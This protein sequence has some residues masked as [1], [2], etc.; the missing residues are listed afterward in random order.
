MKDGVWSEQGSSTIDN[1]VPGVNSLRIVV[2]VEEF[3]VYMNGYKHPTSVSTAELQQF[4]K[5]KFY[6]NNTE[7]FSPIADSIELLHFINNG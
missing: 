6:P 7:C 3:E 5:L 1:L 4:S 2:G